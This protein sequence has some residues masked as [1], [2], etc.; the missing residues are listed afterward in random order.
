M[1]RRRVVSVLDENVQLATGE[2]SHD[3]CNDLA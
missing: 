1:S 2:V 3:G